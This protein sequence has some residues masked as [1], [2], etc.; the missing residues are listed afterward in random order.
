M[1]LFESTLQLFFLSLIFLGGKFK[2]TTLIFQKIDE[3]NV[4]LKIKN[5]ALD[6]DILCLVGVNIAIYLKRSKFHG[7]PYISSNN[8]QL[9]A[10]LG[11]G[12]TYQIRL[13]ASGYP[14]PTLIPSWL[15][16]QVLLTRDSACNNC[17]HE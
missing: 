3:K 2:F 14:N 16:I 12:V 1:V 9:S 17:G 8:R 15:L 7:I 5:F 13:R 6:N 11:F 4:L 10:I